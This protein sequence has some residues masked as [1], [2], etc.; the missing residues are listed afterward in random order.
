MATI[1][2][3]WVGAKVVA[4]IVGANSEKRV[5]E[6]VCVGA[7]NLTPEDLKYLEEP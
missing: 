5:S 2:L 4:P 3:S 1:A 7:V 6:A